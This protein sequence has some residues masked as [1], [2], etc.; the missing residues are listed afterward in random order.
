MPC[1]L[2]RCC[3]AGSGMRLS[4]GEVPYVSHWS[5]FSGV[6]EAL[7]FSH[8]V[9]RRPCPR[10]E[11]SILRKV[12]AKAFWPQFS[13]TSLF[14]CCVRVCFSVA[15]LPLCHP[16]VSSVALWWLC[17]CLRVCLGLRFHGVDTENNM[18]WSFGCHAFFLFVFF[19]L[20]DL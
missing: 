17:L 13:T 16:R 18:L 20:G 9:L 10:M 4:L 3:W 7:R 14:L 5:S 1:N 12:I 19:W 15:V 11:H 6:T 8:E 2:W